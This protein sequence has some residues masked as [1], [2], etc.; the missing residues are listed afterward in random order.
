MACAK[1][2]HGDPASSQNVHEREGLAASPGGRRAIVF[3][4][5]KPLHDVTE[6]AGPVCYNLARDERPGIDRLQG[7]AMHDEY[8]VGLIAGNS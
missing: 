1:G 8:S 2:D 3:L 6:T 7:L 4:N 5:A